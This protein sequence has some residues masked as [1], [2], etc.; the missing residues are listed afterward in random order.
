MQLRIPSIRERIPAP[1]LSMSSYEGGTGVCDP[2]SFNVNSSLSQKSDNSVSGLAEPM[3][4][5]SLHRVLEDA[6]ALAA[7]RSP[8]Q[9]EG[10][11][12]KGS[13]AERA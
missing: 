9:V 11:L 3:C 8:C 5:G 7:V 4:S 1:S 10:L 6:L 2:S 12:D 13:L